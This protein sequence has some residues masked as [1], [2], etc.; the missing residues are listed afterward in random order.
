ME[1]KLL[2]SFEGNGYRIVIPRKSLSN[3]QDLLKDIM[4]HTRMTPYDALQ[5]RPLSSL[6]A[7][8]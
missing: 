7:K 6:I 4:S 8:I 3:L 5:N 2:Q 1:F